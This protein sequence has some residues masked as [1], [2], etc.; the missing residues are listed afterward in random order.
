MSATGDHCDSPRRR[1]LW[2]SIDALS[3]IGRR[4]RSGRLAAGDQEA[5]VV[6]IIERLNKI[7]CAVGEGKGESNKRGDATPAT[8]AVRVRLQLQLQLQSPSWEERYA[9]TAHLG[10]LGAHDT[11][12]VLALL[13]CLRDGHASV[14]A[15]ASTS[16]AVLHQACRHGG[17]MLRM[18][19]HGLLVL[20]DDAE[21]WVR[22]AAR[23]ALV[24]CMMIAIRCVNLFSTHMTDTHTHIEERGRA[25]GEVVRERRSEKVQEK[26]R[27]SDV[28]CKVRKGEKIIDTYRADACMQNRCTRHASHRGA[29]GAAWTPT[30]V[31][32]KSSSTSLGVLRARTFWRDYALQKGSNVDGLRERRRDKAQDE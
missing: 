27:K 16:L 30:T 31:C 14:R 8:G 28:E 12:S 3:S 4:A 17:P 15:A 22:L 1:Q 7:D 5:T 21:V 32:A 13:T 6:G 18:T 20:L 19:V 25:S 29:H 9:A 11:S 24:A 23:K 10:R 26:G 2:Q